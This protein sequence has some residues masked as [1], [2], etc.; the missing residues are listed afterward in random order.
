MGIMG[1]WVYGYLG[2]WVYEYIIINI[3][4]VFIGKKITYK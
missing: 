3:I 1:I 4:I 2:I